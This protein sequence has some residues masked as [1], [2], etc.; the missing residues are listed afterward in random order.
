MLWI[1]EVSSGPLQIDRTIAEKCL[2]SKT[3]Q[4]SRH[5][6]FLGITQNYRELHI[7]TKL[8]TYAKGAEERRE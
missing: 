6:V 5:K 1:F 4:R 2:G 7:N 3:V 8:A